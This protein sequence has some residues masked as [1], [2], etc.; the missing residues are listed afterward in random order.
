MSSGEGPLAT[1]YAHCEAELRAEHHDA[2]LATLLAPADARP[3]LHALGAFVHEVAQVQFRVR[4]PVAGEIRLQW[5]QD[6]IDG[7]RAS[8]AVAHPVA[9]ALLDTV[10]HAMLPAAPFGDLLD[11]FRMA[12]YDEP[13]VDIPAM[14]HR[15]LAT[16]GMPIRLAARVLGGGA[17]IDTAAD[18][19]GIALGIAELLGDLRVEPGIHPVLLPTELMGR[20]GAARADLDA[21]RATPGVTAA[22]S[23]LAALARSRLA[24]LRVRRGTLGPAAPAFLTMALVEPVLAKAERASDPFTPLP[25]VPPWRRQ[26][27]LWRAARRGGVL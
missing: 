11:G 22:V 1:A 26:W 23:E 14:E 24:Q 21:R 3:H 25:E 13:P 20:H 12:L 7:G 6:V 8:E 27:R 18:E 19:A 17:G 16:H 4:Q 9:A 2:W 15:F 10:R 5:W